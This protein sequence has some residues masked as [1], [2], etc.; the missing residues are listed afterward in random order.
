MRFSVVR[1]QADGFAKLR[2]GIVGLACVKQRLTQTVVGARVVGLQGHSLVPFRNR[3]VVL[4]LLG[5]VGRQIELLV[6]VHC[7]RVDVFDAAGFHVDELGN[8]YGAICSR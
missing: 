7:G 4:A 1:V 6:K 3:F 2:N 8:V 5:Q